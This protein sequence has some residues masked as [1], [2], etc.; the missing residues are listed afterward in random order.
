MVKIDH[1]TCVEVVNY[2]DSISKKVERKATRK[3][4]KLSNKS[5]AQCVRYADDQV[6]AKYGFRIRDLFV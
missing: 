1:D 2:F 3:L 6:E 4:G 5:L